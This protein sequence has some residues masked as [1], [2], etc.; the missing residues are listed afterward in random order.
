MP[1]SGEGRKQILIVAEAPGQNEDEQGEPFVGRAGKLLDDIIGAI[2][3]RRSDVYIANMVK[4]RPPG[5]RNPT[6]E[7]V[8]ACIPFLYR[9][10]QLIEPKVIL[11][12]G[13]VAAGYVS[14]TWL[15]RTT[16]TELAGGDRAEL[17]IGGLLEH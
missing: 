17:A 3:L 6:Q 7:E 11:A 12:V 8:E 2:G 4:C 1:L 16:L 9:Q 13:A 10:I 15:S 5:N 14:T